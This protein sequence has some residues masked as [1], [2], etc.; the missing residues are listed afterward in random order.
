MVVP[1]D[2]LESRDLCA[3]GLAL[4]LLSENT[5][6]GPLHGGGTGF[7]CRRDRRNVT[8]SME[9][10]C[11]RFV[12]DGTRGRLSCFTSIRQKARACLLH[13]CPSSRR[14]VLVEPWAR[15]EGGR[16]VRSWQCSVPASSSGSVTIACAEGDVLA[17]KINTSI[18]KPRREYRCFIVFGS[19]HV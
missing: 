7:L 5:Q 10:C 12:L 14:H 19:L 2:Y 13:W 16:V 18:W 1:F 9:G 11:W 6:G 4:V 3:H 8:P 17:S 15:P